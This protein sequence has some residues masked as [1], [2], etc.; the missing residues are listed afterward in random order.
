M[1]FISARTKIVIGL[2]GLLISVLL[3]ALAMGL[4]PDSREAVLKLRAQYCEA[5]AISSSALLSHQDIAGVNAL[6]QSLV[7]R[8]SELQAV[9]VR[10]TDGHILAWAGD[11][12]LDRVVAAGTWSTES[13]VSVLVREN[14]KPFGAI[15]FHFKPLSAPGI[16]GYLFS[17]RV[18]MVLFIAA[19][20]FVAYLL[21]LRKMLQHLDPSK[22]VPQRVRS[23]LD[24]LISGLFVL[25]TSER[26]VLANQAFSQAVG[27]S[28][29]K[30]LGCRAWKLPW[31]MPGNDDALAEY[32]WTRV[33]QSGNVESNVMIRLRCVGDVVRTFMVNCSPVLGGSSSARGVLVSLEDITPLEQKEAELRQSRDAADKANSAKSEFLARMSHEI[34]TPLNAILGFADVLRRGFAENEQERQEYL[35]TIHSSGQHLLALINDILDL[36][37]VESGRMELEKVRCSPHQLIRQVAV[38]LSI[39]AKEKGLSL[40]YSAPY[41]LPEVITTDPVRFRQV[42]FN[43]VGNAIKFTP[44]GSVKIVARMFTADQCRKLSI[45]VIDS[46]IG[47]SDESLG[48]I[49]KPFVQADT[50]ITRQFGGTGLGL[51]ISRRLVEAM[52]GS[53]TVKSQPGRG[54]T[55]TMT[56]DPGDLTGVSTISAD[57]ASAQISTQSATARSANVNASSARVLVVDDGDSNR[58]LARLVLERAGMTVRLA[59]NGADAVKLVAS[60]SFDVILMD[61][62]MPIMDGF[63]ATAELRERGCKL[64]IIAMTADAMKGDE[65]KCRAAGCSG[66]L[67]KPI[68]MD[69]MLE[70]VAAAAQAN[71]PRAE[72]S[73]QQSKPAVSAQT[74]PVAANPPAPEPLEPIH[75]R[76]PADD[77]EFCQIVDEFLD[78]LRQQLDAMQKA[79]SAE[80]LRQLAAAAHWLK[81]SGGTAGFDAF[82]KP[83]TELERLAKESQIERI[84]PALAELQKLAGRAQGHGNPSA[85][86]VQKST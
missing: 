35:G 1:N 60:E 55:F 69:R 29:E 9:A 83:A 23:A 8:N 74:A 17:E 68:D 26:I 18:R 59:E 11:Q 62:H 76:L 27:Q 45:D 33:L 67:P 64:P 85:T 31:Q 61:M 25:D 41:G 16:W 54:S 39:R 12:L 20:C 21:Y 2:V 22:A 43:L 82:T 50:S 15:E 32:P 37:K 42:L 28:T 3:S 58:K 65:D 24:N 70:T 81:G 79:L 38:E 5:M 6:L 36:S 10:R 71:R 78:R 84:A 49:F 73:A 14:D 48:K 75:S 72:V 77:P 40:E 57:S 80:D 47:M 63:A 7:Q 30:L 86:K 19:G 13:N 46:G 66:F 56:I 52:G 34:R 44:Q 4:I 53:I 51:S